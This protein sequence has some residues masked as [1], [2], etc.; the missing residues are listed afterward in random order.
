VTL[1]WQR[2]PAYDGAMILRLKRND[3]L[4]LRSA[5]G[6]AIEVLSGRVWV[7]EDGAT[8]DHF[9]SPGHRYRVGGDGLV[10]VGTESYAGDGP[11]AEIAV[12]PAA[13]QAQQ[14]RLRYLGV[15]RLLGWM[16]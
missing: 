4:R 13:A 10:I 11:G 9:L 3:F 2:G 14:Q 1:F 8:G 16:V 5:R 6:A 12:R 15:K 7:T